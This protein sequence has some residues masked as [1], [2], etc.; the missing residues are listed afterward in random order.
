MGLSS[1]KIFK[2]KRKDYFQKNQSVN[3]ISRAQGTGCA[4]QVQQGVYPGQTR[5]DG[6]ICISVAEWLWLCHTE[7]RL[8]HL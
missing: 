6:C 8:I 5:G 3:G 7:S 1:F 2:L 4:A